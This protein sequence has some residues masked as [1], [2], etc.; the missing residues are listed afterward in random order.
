VPN[1]P[2]EGLMS[3]LGEVP[4][5][6]DLAALVRRPLFGARSWLDIM[7]ANDGAM[8]A[9]KVE[10]L[11]RFALSP[12]PRGLVEDVFSFMKSGR[13][14]VGGDDVRD[15]IR[16]YSGP[17]LLFFAPRDN[18]IHPEFATPMRDVLPGE[19][20]VRVL[21]VLEGSAVDL[22]HFG[23]LFADS[24]RLSTFGPI[25]QFLKEKGGAQ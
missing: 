3:L 4:P 25:V 21:S 6:L 19:K 23:L 16:R 22:G 11:R 18:W 24:A 5:W 20:Q 2:V 15:T 1:E 17:S 12:V 9:E 13:V 14:L 8:P 7:V 10:R